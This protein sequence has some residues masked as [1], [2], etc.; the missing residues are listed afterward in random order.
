MFWLL[1]ALYLGAAA[2]EV[3]GIVL[4]VREMRRAR[5]Y[6]RLGNYNIIDGG[7]ASGKVNTPGAAGEVNDWMLR[8]SANRTAAVVLL[9][10][11]VGLGTAGNIVSLFHP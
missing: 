2:A 8:S 3:V 6:L 11:G 4:I 1:L 7:N 9:F 5:S 10:L